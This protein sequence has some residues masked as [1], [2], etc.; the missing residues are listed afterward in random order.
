MAKL[1][2]SITKK[3]WIFITVIALLMIIITAVPYLY[4]YFVRG[5]NMV[6]TGIHHF[7]PGDTNVYL[8]MIEQVKQDNN[9]LINMYTSEPQLRLQVKPFWLAV[10]YMAKILNLSNLM[11]FH[12]ARSILIFIFVFVIYIFVSYF[13]KNINYKKIILLIL[14]FSS[15]L[16]FLFN[17]FLYDQNNIY[18]HPADIWITESNTFNTLFHSP[19]MI[20]SMTLIVVI[21]LM[22]LLAFKY[23]HYRYSIAAGFFCLLMLWAH[24]FNGPTIYAVLGLYILLLFL[25][26]KKILWSYVRHFA[27]LS[28]IPLPAVLYF[29]LIQKADWVI[30]FWNSQNILPSPSVWMYVIGYGFLL[31]LAI[32]GLWITIRKKDEEKYFL[33]IWFLTSALL[34]YFPIYFQRRLS[35]GLHIPIAILAGVGAI[36]IYNFSQ[37]KYGKNNYMAIVFMMILIVFLPMTCFQVMGQDFYLYNK[38]KDNPYYF[39]LYQDEVE[40]M[41]WLRDNL[42][43]EEVVFS[44]KLTG[45]FIPAYSGRIVWIGHGPQTTD[46]NYKIAIQDWFWEN[47]DNSTEKYEM[48]NHYGVDYIFYSGMEKSLGSY[49]PSTKNYLKEVFKNSQVTIYKVL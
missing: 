42:E 13:I 40:A 44:S 30:R 32:I 6:Y 41:H 31:I 11:A 24:P 8:S 33:I 12:V 25:K 43:I 10:G 34:I 20:F 3:E 26:N 2:K 35:E 45:N 18:E 16:G 48:L 1:L 7:A 37:K 5:E 46:L 27:I 29:Y 22:M 19:H 21:F 28:F 38:A 23:N 15:G 47:D 14:I 36:Y 4:G 39:Y 9:I 49:D 17:P